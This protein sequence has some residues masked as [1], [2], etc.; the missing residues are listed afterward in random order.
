MGSFDAPDEKVCM[1]ID[2]KV[3]A[4]YGLS[5]GAKFSEMADPSV[6]RVN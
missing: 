6:A 4:L 2:G 3:Y 1:R 5:K